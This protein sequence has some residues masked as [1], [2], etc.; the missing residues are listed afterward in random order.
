MNKTEYLLTCLVEECAEVQKEATKALRFGLED[1]WRD[2]GKQSERIVHEFCDLISIYDMLVEEG[3]IDDVTTA[4][5][6]EMKKQRV[7][8]YMHY[9]R[10]RGTLVD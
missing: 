4:E 8:K 3:L 7:H 10:E 9:A 2:Q 6:I 5:M 1:N